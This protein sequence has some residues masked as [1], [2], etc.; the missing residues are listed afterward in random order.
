VASTPRT[1]SLVELAADLP[2]RVTALV[3]AEIQLLK[4]EVIG[5]L[6]ALGIGAGVLLGAVILLGFM[7]GVLLTAAI[8]ALA[9][10]MP[11]WLAALLVAAFLLIVAAILALIGWRI[12]KKGIPPI[13]SESIH[14][15][16]SD[17]RTVRGLVR[18]PE[19]R[20]AA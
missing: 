6:K 7:F 11:G 4:T 8:L 15:L 17:V 18:R 5:K 2:N 9:L 3:Q 14:S 1:P 20:G 12:L 13:P 10:V 16:Q 19:K